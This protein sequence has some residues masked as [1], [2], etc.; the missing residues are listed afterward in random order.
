M[1]VTNTRKGE[2]VVILHFDPHGASLMILQDMQYHVPNAK[3]EIEGGVYL[4][5]FLLLLDKRTISEMNPK[6]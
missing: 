1:V 6:G 2:R 5:V 3:V 4:P